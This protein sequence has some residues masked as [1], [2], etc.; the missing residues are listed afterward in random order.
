MVIAL[1]HRQRIA[2]LTPLDDV[3]QRITE[4]VAAVAPREIASPAALGATLAED[5][6]VGGPRPAAPLAL[7]DGW[8]VHAELT[9]Y[10]EAY[11]P[12]L[13]ANPRE[14]AVG[15]MLGTD[16]D[17]VAPLDAV[18]WRGRRRALTCELPMAMT[19][20]DGVLLPG[21]DAGAG[22][23]LWQAGHRMRA[24]DVAVLQ[25]L[26]IPAAQVRRPRIRIAGASDRRDGIAD[27]IVNWMTCAITADGGEPVAATSDARTDA[28]LAADGADAVIVVGGTG[29]GAGDD[30][31]RALRRAGVVAT[32]GIAMLPGETAA[33]G[34]ACSR[35]VLLVPGRLDA[36]VAAWL[37]IGRPLLERLCAST[38]SSPSHQSV[39]TGKVASTVGLTELVLVRRAGDGVA[40]LASRYLPL[41]TL[42]H[43]DGWIVIPAASEGLAPGAPVTVRPFP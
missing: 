38:E 9:A 40:P 22:E 39:L 28:L 3:T 12:A 11:T 10:A 29:S 13:L 14:V 8:A 5:I 18:T 6:A 27:A 33:F 30:S 24:R 32:H 36:A 41:S 42:A 7:I 23:V 34:M 43:A 31:V 21:T 26:G 4:D 1:E 35:P 37:M 2:C 15:D 25:A 17:A 19:P 20:G 16:G